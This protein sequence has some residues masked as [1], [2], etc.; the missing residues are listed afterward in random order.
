MSTPAKVAIIGAGPYGLSLASHLRARGV[1]FYIFGRPME[2]WR[3][4]MVEGMF[5]KSDGFASNLSDPEGR[6]TLRSYCGQRG[7]AYR[8][9]GVPIPRHVFADYALEFQR[10]LVPN[11]DEA[12]V[13]SLA[14]VTG[15]FVLTL[16][17]GR[18]ITAGVVV[19]AVGLGYFKQLP[20]TLAHL[21]PDHL[22]HS[23]DHK[24]VDR[25]HKREVIVLGSGASAMDLA[26]QL[27]EHGAHTQVV[28]RS[29][30]IRFQDR[31][32]EPR[33]LWRRLR[34]P[35]SPIGLGWRSQ[36]ISDAPLLFHS[37]PETV[38]L[39]TVQGYL[40]PTPGWF[41]KEMV[42]GRIPT[43]AGL[44]VRGAAIRGG[45]VH[46]QLADRRGAEQEM[47]A[48]HVVAAT[49][50]RLDARRLD[51]V[52]SGLLAELK[53]AGDTPVLS[54]DFQSSVP[55]LYFSGPLSSNSFGP[56]MRFVVGAEFASRRIA[57]HL[58]EFGSRSVAFSPVTV[59]AR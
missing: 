22:T 11:V 49:G 21:S 31:I 3:E 5:L 1:P 40:Q 42:V 57:L 9:L 39:R 48:D 56:P 2:T 26:I 58:A 4:K 16:S 32:V 23:A 27:H 8:D 36:I 54:R 41:T 44:S 19:V 46:L 52:D 35:A 17:D 30:E 25:F 12:V 34:R 53:L 15:G 7:I 6:F 13:V 45:K 14:H 33:T 29:A 20:A 18:E 59:T 10:R 51:F 24:R 55:G 47:A 28:A 50:Y 38:R 43:H 37:L